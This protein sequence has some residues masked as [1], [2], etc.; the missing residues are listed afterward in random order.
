MHNIKETDVQTWIEMAW[1]GLTNVVKSITRENAGICYPMEKRGLYLQVGERFER[2][3]FHVI[4][5]AD[6]KPI[7]NPVG[8]GYALVDNCR[9]FDR[10][11][12]ALKG[13]KHTLVSCGSVGN[14]EKVFLS[15]Q[16][17]KEFIAAGRKTNSVLNVLWGHGGTLGVIAKTGITVVVCGNTQQIAL[18]ERGEFTFKFKHTENVDNKLLGMEKAI[19][20]HVGVVAEF[21]KA[22]RDCAA[23]PCKVE[24]AR[25]IF[26]GFLVRED[27]MKTAEKTRAKFEIALAEARTKGAS[28]DTIKI[29]EESKSR[30]VSTRTINIVDTMQALFGDEKRGN[31]G[32]NM[33]DCFNA[34]TDYYTHDSS[35]GNDKW[36]QFESSEFGQGAVRKSEAY[37]LIARDKRVAGLG[38]LAE[39]IKRGDRVLQMA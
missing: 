21:T 13:T 10:V 11:Q 27:R 38:T 3:P 22:M 1:H 18:A 37:D 25:Q 19:E 8:D 24:T 12:E 23:T 20:Q 9:M 5:A 17:D 36:K 35:G 28:G 32:A 6:N 15:V 31:K 33:A 30:D 39:T 34:I 29:L 16:L 14:R 7:G 2:V 4:T 26:A